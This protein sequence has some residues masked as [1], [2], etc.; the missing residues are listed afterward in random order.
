MINI[1]LDKEVTFDLPEGIYSATISN[2][3][4]F[5]K[6]T[7]KGRQDWIRI[8]WEVV[9][10]RKERLDCRAAR[11]F[12]LSLKAGSDLRNFL[13]PILSNQFFLQNSNSTID[14]EM[15]LKGL[16]GQITLS[17]FLGADYDKPLVVVDAFE[18][19]EAKD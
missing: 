14:L 18:V 13:S 9:V 2:I 17:H 1:E 12:L 4:T 16:T 15:L 5:F 11:S 7:S 10:P 3:K 6:Q 8:T 19:H